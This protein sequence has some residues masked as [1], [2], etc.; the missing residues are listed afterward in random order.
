MDRPV[1]SRHFIGVQPVCI[2]QIIA[3]ESRVKDF[4]RAFYPLSSHEKSR[5]LSVAQAIGSGVV[6]PAIE[7][8][9]VGD[10]Y[11]V[12]D[13]H[14]RISVYRALQMS[15]IDARVVEWEVD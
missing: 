15:Y 5:W 8:I 6:L 1:K 4:D 3:S 12:R 7:L 11:I 9:K 10:I 2:D 13:G 14:H